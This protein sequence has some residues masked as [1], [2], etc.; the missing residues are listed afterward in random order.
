M[1][2]LN[3]AMIVSRLIALLNQTALLTCEHLK[4][5]V[6]I[7]DA[8]H[9]YGQTRCLVTPLNGSGSQWVVLERLTLQTTPAD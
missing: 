1:K 2:S 5:P 6:T 9:C 4:V 8:K 3:G 7:Q